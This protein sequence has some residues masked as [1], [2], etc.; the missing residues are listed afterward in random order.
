MFLIHFNIIFVQGLGIFFLLTF[1]TIA[2][3]VKEKTK[4]TPPSHNFDE[5]KLRRE[6]GRLTTKS[7]VMRRKSDRMSQKSCRKCAHPSLRIKDTTDFSTCVAC[8]DLAVSRDHP[9][10][11][12]NFD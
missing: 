10:G 3:W 5:K 8:F 9:Q 12:S 4:K 7:L 11:L 2:S 6:T 1:A